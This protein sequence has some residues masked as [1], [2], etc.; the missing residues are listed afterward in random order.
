MFTEINV[1]GIVLVFFLII[2]DFSGLKTSACVYMVVQA[3][4]HEFPAGYLHNMN[5]PPRK[6]T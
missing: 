6:L 5:G 1:L 3:L 2:T 4:L